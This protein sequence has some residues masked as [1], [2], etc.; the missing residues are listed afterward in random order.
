MHK[1]LWGYGVGCVLFSGAVLAQAESLCAP[2]AGAFL[3]RP[4]AQ[5]LAA[6]KREDDA[7][8]WQILSSGDAA[9]RLRHLVTQGNQEAAIYLAQHLVRLDPAGQ[10]EAQ[11]ALGQF[12]DRRMGRFLLMVRQGLLDHPSAINALVMTPASLAG[13]TPAQLRLLRARRQRLG[14][15]AGTT[16]APIQTEALR[17]LDAAIA[18]RRIRK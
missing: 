2:A 5:T 13:D 9:V 14:L 8:C 1:A 7:A 12:A 15:R 17:A 16:H 6:L 10:E 11:R 4:N 3:Q 18:E